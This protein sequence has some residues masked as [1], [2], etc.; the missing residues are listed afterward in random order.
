MGEAVDKSLSHLTAGDIAAIVAYLRS[1][2]ASLH[3]ICPR[4]SRCRHLHR[5]GKESSPATILSGKQIFEDACASC[6]G[7][8]GVSP[9]THYATLTGVRAVNDPT[10]INV[11]ETVVNGT[12]YMPAFGQGYSDDEIAA[13]AN[14][15]TARFGVSASRITARDVAALRKQASK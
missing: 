6:H 14:Y 4:R 8:T 3:P 13:V 7:W 2:P 1:V 10:A 12:D 15:V 11:A 5:I 9:L